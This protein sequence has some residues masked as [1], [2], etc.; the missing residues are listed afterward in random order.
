MSAL[1]S[2]IVIEAGYE[3]GVL[4]IM[5]I[6]QELGTEIVVSCRDVLGGGS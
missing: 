6:L 2:A 5:V 1:T 3:G 4:L